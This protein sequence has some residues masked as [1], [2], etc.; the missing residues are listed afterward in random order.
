MT[1][2]YSTAIALS[3]GFALATLAVVWYS[4]ETQKKR[5]HSSIGKDI[6]REKI[7]AKALGLTVS[8]DGFAEKF[9]G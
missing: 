8:D 6:E 7:R 9:K 2:R 4:D 1:S 3:G 5:R